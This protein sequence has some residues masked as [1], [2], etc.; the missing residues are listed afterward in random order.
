M[1][2]DPGARGASCAAC[3]AGALTWQLGLSCSRRNYASGKQPHIVPGAISETGPLTLRTA[4]FS[5][6]VT[7][8]LPRR[9]GEMGSPLWGRANEKKSCGAAAAKCAR[10]AAL[11]LGW[12]ELWNLLLDLSSTRMLQH[13]RSH[14]CCLVVPLSS[15]QRGARF[16]AVK[17]I[18]FPKTGSTLLWLRDDCTI[19]GINP[20]TGRR[21]YPLGN[22]L[23]KYCL[24]AILWDKF[25]NLSNRGNSMKLFYPKLIQA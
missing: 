1:G 11:A 20:I 16:Q 12:A 14:C 4:V 15:H 2:P 22:K 23:Y 25:K 24:Y 18:L 6:E 17:Y 7:T 3:S 13:G 10:V 9:F 8:D 5:P 21:F 19:I